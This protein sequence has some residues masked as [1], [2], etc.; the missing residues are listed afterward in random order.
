MTLE[1][2]LKQDRRHTIIEGMIEA[3]PARNVVAAARELVHRLRGPEGLE[4]YNSPYLAGLA[5]AT[6]FEPHLNADLLAEGYAKYAMVEQGQPQPDAFARDSARLLVNYT[7]VGE[8]FAESAANQP[9]DNVARYIA[10]DNSFPDELDQGARIPL[11]IAA[12]R[13]LSQEEAINLDRSINYEA[14]ESAFARPRASDLAQAEYLFD[15]FNGHREAY[16][17]PILSKTLDRD[18]DIISASAFLW[19]QRA[20]FEPPFEKIDMVEVMAHA[21]AA[22]EVGQEPVDAHVL[23]GMSFDLELR[24]EAKTLLRVLDDPATAPSLTIL[25]AAVHA[26]EETIRF[27]KAMEIS[28]FDRLDPV[29]AHMIRTQ[30]NNIEN[31]SEVAVE[32]YPNILAYSG[33]IRDYLKSEGS[34]S[35]VF[36]P[37]PISRQSAEGEPSSGL[38]GAKSALPTIADAQ[39]AFVAR[40]GIGR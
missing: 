15:V 36:P 11:I 35:S 1:P 4:R 6:R 39:A 26:D 3:E 18:A 14:D 25:N 28:R 33:L 17:D 30:R 19:E 31:L 7:R 12:D 21:I 5:A 9:L 13:M 34:L 37:Q 8:A 22:R 10:A 32:A 40:S 20:A 38:D 27:F 29:D 16:E 2:K 24:G 23:Q